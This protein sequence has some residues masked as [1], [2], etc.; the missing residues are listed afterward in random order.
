MKK[1]LSTQGM[2]YAVS[3]YLIWGA[4]PLFWKLLDQVPSLELLAHRILW[5]IPFLVLILLLTKR[6]KVF[7]TEIK[8][9]T[10]KKWMGLILATLLLLVN[11]FTFIW[12]VTNGHI[13]DTSLGYYINPIVSVLLG[14]I[15][16]KES[17][18]KQQWIAFGIVVFGVL[19]LMTTVHTLPW[20]AFTLAFSFGFYGLIKKQLKIKPVTSLTLEMI[21]ASVFSI[22]Y[23]SLNTHAG[24]FTLGLTKINILLIATGVVTA[25]PLLLF[26]TGT[27][28]LPL[29]WMGILQYIAPTISLLIGIF[30]FQEKFT[31][32]HLLSFCVIWI[33]LILFSISSFKINKKVNLKEI[34]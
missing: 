16:L 31:S 25:L 20:I 13:V 10:P 29:F 22:L 28:K 3:S 14:V 4:T 21:L 7:K 8:Q 6:I 17:L 9:F 11:W 23:L 33:G 32:M 12:A 2:F 26:N 34:A 15:V 18:K 30:V 27:S 19:V 1:D 24:S 5:S